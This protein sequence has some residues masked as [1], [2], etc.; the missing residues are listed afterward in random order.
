MYDD[1]GSV[2]GTIPPPII[3]SLVAKFGFDLIQWYIS[4]RLAP[5]LISASIDTYYITF[6]YE[7]LSN[8]SLNYSYEMVLLNR[9]LT[10]A[11]NYFSGLGVPCKYYSAP[12]GLIDSQKIVNNICA[13]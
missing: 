6:L 4:S 9:G 2:Y 5:Y 13:S 10:D 7:N 12:L 11:D 3:I 1:I 8:L